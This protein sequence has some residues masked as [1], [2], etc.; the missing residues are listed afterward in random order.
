MT[1]APF[2]TKVEMISAI[3]IPGLMSTSLDENGDLLQLTACDISNLHAEVKVLIDNGLPMPDALKLVTSNPAKRVGLQ[4]K[5][6][7]EP[8]KDADLLITSPD[9]DV[10]S[11]MAR[12]QIMIHEGQVLVKG[13][14]ET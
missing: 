14:F 2:E 10:E 12:G 5:G 3:A 4:A 1:S 9:F 7:L 6:K 11:V 8:G 13:T